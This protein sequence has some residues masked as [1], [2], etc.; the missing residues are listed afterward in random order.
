VHVAGFVGDQELSAYLQAADICACLRWPTNRETS[1]SWLRCLAAGRTTMITD[2]SHLGD[3][4]T[5]DPRGWRTLD[6]LGSARE[7]VAVSIDLLDEEHSLQLAIERLATDAPMRDRLGRAGR[8]WYETHHR[9][10]PMA[11]AY[12]RIIVTAA[13]LPAP[14]VLLPAH[15]TDDTSHHARMLADSIGVSDRL[16]DVFGA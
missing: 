8:A 11:D 16:A 14:R 3:V 1:A 5:V 13:A 12:D 6:T 4:P 15:L 7:P 9:L 10:E 2:L